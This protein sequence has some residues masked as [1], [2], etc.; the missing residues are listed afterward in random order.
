MKFQKINIATAQI[1]G[2]RNPPYYF[3]H[4][5]Y[6][7]WDIMFEAPSTLLFKNLPF[8][9]VGD[10]EEE[11]KIFCNQFKENFNK[12]HIYDGDKVSILFGDD[13]RVLAI[14]NSGEDVW[15]DT[16]DKFAKKTFAD[17]NIVITSLKV[18]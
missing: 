4:R 1:K 3:S 15:I 6:Y 8:I 5:G 2:L 11:G 14:G 10:T 12:A 9:K 18:Y 17:L 13:G 16:S 7:A